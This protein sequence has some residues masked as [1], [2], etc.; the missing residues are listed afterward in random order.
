MEAPVN[1]RQFL[2][3]V[4]RLPGVLEQH[5]QHIDLYVLDVARGRGSAIMNNSAP[6][7]YA[8]GKIVTASLTGQIAIVDAAREWEVGAVTNLDEQVWSTPAIAGDALLLRGTKKLYCIR[9]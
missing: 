1:A 7:D 9:N 4:F 3:F 6:S 5:L 2:G 8:G